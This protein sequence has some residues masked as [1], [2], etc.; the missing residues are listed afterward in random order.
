MNIRNG[1]TVLAA[2]AVLAA[3][4]GGGGGG[5]GNGTAVGGSPAIGGTGT[6]V[7]DSPGSG[8]GVPPSALTS[9]GAL[10]AYMSQLIAG[11]NDA[12]EPL[13]LGDLTLPVDET[14]EPAAL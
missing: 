10:V 13:T 7:G 12:S 1:W 2:C 11:S 8:G 9:V 14:A 6:S 3:C 4:G 5:G